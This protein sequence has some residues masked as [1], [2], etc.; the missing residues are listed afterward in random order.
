M[1]TWRKD[2][3]TRTT[4]MGITWPLLLSLGFLLHPVTSTDDPPPSTTNPPTEL[5][6]AH[7]MPTVATTAAP[8]THTVRP[9][10]ATAAATK[11]TTAKMTTVAATT[12]A[13][14]T[15]A[16]AATTVA[17]TMAATTAAATTAA[18]EEAAAAATTAAEEEAAA[19]TTAAITTMPENSPTGA[20]AIAHKHTTHSV[21]SRAP[22][23]S[24]PAHVA[25]ET[26]ATTMNPLDRGT[27]AVSTRPHTEGPSVQPTT[28]AVAPSDSH[29]FGAPLGTQQTSTSG[30]GTRGSATERIEMTS[31]DVTMPTT[32]AGSQQESKG[33]AGPGT[34]SITSHLNTPTPTAVL[35]PS[36]T[37][38]TRREPLDTT[39]VPAPATTGPAEPQ[40][41]TFEFSLKSK[42]EEQRD[43]V[44][45]CKRLMVNMEDGK[46]ILKWQ[47]NSNKVQFES[48]E[49]S[50]TGKLTLANQFHNELTKKPN[51]STTLIAILTSCGA[52]LIMII[53]L[54][55]C[56]SHHRKPYSETQ[57]HLTEE[58]HTV[59]NGYHDNPTLEVMEVQP[60]MQ[61]KKMALNGDFNDSWIVPIDNLLKEDLPDEEDTHL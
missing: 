49:I 53:S 25:A 2:S 44:E 31:T 5:P 28:A 39:S 29:T 30:S 59:E 54:A 50:G 38:R 13:A 51:D 61:E 58:L 26:G 55:V 34:I 32:A 19:A 17:T 60:E 43:F 27:D 48:V 4:T 37:T 18:V 56:A 21:S 24:S 57:Q 42:N 36:S 16:T 12:A 14:T 46:C 40:L 23:D 47:N 20:T 45:V 3:S 33:T 8:T 1:R 52:L 35:P 6:A 10:A 22:S 11:T 15:A 7:A 9:T 41:K